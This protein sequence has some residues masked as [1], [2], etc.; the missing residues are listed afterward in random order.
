MRNASHSP[1]GRIPGVSRMRY[2]SVRRVMQERLLLALLALA[3]SVFHVDCIESIF[4]Y[5]VI[6]DGVGKQ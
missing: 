4:T 2:R 6:M 3:N 5:S 1:L